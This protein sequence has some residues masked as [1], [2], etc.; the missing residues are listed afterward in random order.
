MLAVLGAMEEEIARLRERLTHVREETVARIRVF[1]GSFDGTEIILAQTGIGKVSAAICTQMIID[2][3]G[4]DRLLFCGVAGG[5]APNMQPGDIVV[6]SHL[7]Q[8]DMDLTAFGRRL[9]EIPGLGRLLECDPELVQLAAAA[10]DDAFPGEDAPNLM[11]GTVASAD[12]FIKDRDEQ[13]RLQREFSALATEMEGAAAGQTCYVNDVPFV[14]VRA[15]SDGASQS[16]QDEF[17]SNLSRA[18]ANGARLMEKLIPAAVAS[19]VA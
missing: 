2:S 1:R 7:I 16:A 15:I 13:R 17:S 14:V 18:A 3:Y 4:A 12:R 9:G 6:A 19:C 5:L 11:I 10:F 8:Y